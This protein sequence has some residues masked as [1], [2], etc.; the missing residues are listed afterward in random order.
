MNLPTRNTPHASRTT[1]LFGQ[2]AT[3]P[4]CDVSSAFQTTVNTA[5]A[6]TAAVR[7]PIRGVRSDQPS[8]ERAMKRVAEELRRPKSKAL[9]HS[10]PS[11][12][13]RSASILESSESV[14]STRFSLE[15][16]YV[17][18]GPTPLSGNTSEFQP[19]AVILDRWSQLYSRLLCLRNTRGCHLEYSGSL[20]L[21]S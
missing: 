21:M 4:R 20:P 5:L 16:T 3:F 2:S 12:L 6:P 1:A 18:C 19:S 17:L 7:V 14:Y 15:T 10:T 13:R 9:D 8:V 11:G